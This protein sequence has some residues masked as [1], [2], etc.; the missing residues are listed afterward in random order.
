MG[1]MKKHILAQNWLTFN[2]LGLTDEPTLVDD[3]TLRRLNHMS[4]GK[5]NEHLLYFLSV[6]SK[7]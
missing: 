5:K 3:F 1:F 6:N 7:R 2:V 4:L